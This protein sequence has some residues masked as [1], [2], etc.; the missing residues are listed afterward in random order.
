MTTDIQSLQDEL[1]ADV[2][3]ASDLGGLESVRVTALG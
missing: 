1:L 3:A 2:E